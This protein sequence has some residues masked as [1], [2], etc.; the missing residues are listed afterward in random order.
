MH[1]S[2]RCRQFRRHMTESVDQSDICLQLVWCCEIL[3]FLLAFTFVQSLLHG[4]DNVH[5]NWFL[6]ERRLDQYMQ[7]WLPFLRRS[8]SFGAKN[9]LAIE[10]TKGGFL[11]I[12]HPF[13]T[14]L[15]I[16]DL[17]DAQR[18]WGCSGSSL[19]LSKNNHLYIEDIE[20]NSIFR[21]LSSE[22]M[23]KTK[24]LSRP[25]D[26]AKHFSAK[27]HLGVTAKKPWATETL[28]QGWV[29]SV[30]KFPWSI[31][32][33]PS[34]NRDSSW[35]PGHLFRSRDHVGGWAPASFGDAGDTLSICDGYCT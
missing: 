35:S 5:C 21:Y 17:C 28:P 25:G 12:P 11:N 7:K 27:C 1:P 34:L 23:D 26:V 13:G 6:K 19:Q 29:K 2:W 32:I 10:S 16:V 31:G 18:W 15:L 3:F 8:K 24:S 22:S 30:R 9:S 4:F 14:D 20:G 33:E